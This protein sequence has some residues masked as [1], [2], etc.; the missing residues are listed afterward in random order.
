M[1]YLPISCFH[2]CL[3][4]LPII[5]IFS[6]ALSSKILAQSAVV[7]GLVN[8]AASGEAVI[9]VTVF[10]AK[11]STITSSASIL[12]GTRTN[13]FG[14][15]SLPSLPQG[16]YYLVVKGI[17]YRPFIKIITI[18]AADAALRVNVPLAAISIRTQEVV[19][20]TERDP[21]A[22]RSI[23]AVELKSE[24][25]SKMPTLGGETDIF[26]VL[27][28][29]PGIKAGSEIS[30]G[31]YVRGG[32]P[33]QNLTLLD[34]VIVYNPSHLG[35]FLSVFNNDAIRDTRVIKGGFPAEYGGRLSSVI[36]LT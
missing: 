16:S 5:L 19:L 28:L 9:G 3:K 35:G 24:F 20:Q 18:S 36:D 7:S 12:S 25:I 32:S 34:G 30:S 10:L 13:K 1:K 22:T 14:F 11:D 2:Q 23:S 6:I 31:L 27:Q 15:Y 33:D 4:I 26:R 8:E 21:S 29:M 17:G